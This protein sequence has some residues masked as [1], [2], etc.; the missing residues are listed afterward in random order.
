MPCSVKANLF[1]AFQGRQRPHGL[2]GFSQSPEFG[3]S[4][5]KTWNYLGASLD[6]CYES[7][8]WISSGTGS[9]SHW[10]LIIENLAVFNSTTGDHN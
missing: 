4:S 6:H 7:T 5:V 1:E 8:C 2:L 3:E 10:N 9:I